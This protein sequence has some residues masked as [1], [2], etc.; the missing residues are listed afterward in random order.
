MLAG[1]ANSDEYLTEE[2]VRSLCDE[3]LGYVNL[4]RKRILIIIPDSTRTVPLPIF[5]R[6]FHEI[7]GDRAAALDYLVALGT[8][9]PMSE[10]ALNRLVGISA[11]ER[12]SEYACWRRDIQSSVG[13]G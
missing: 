10:E 7:L 9:Q 13:S 6:M 12:D 8:H 1:E 11:K 4:D 3:A 2:R 5:F